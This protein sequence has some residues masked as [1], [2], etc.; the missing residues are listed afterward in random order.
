M[1]RLNRNPYKSWLVNTHK[2]MEQIIWKHL[3]VYNYKALNYN[4][5]HC[6]ALHCTALHYTTHHHT[7]LHYT[8]LNFTALHW[9]ASHC[10]A[11]HCHALH[12]TALHCTTLHCTAMNLYK[13]IGY[14]PGTVPPVSRHWS[15]QSGESNLRAQNLARLV[16]MCMLGSGRDQSTL[17]IWQGRKAVQDVQWSYRLES[18][19]RLFQISFKKLLQGSNLH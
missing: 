13:T 8:S 6:T 2:E 15:C 9:S 4:R 17:C 7:A 19:L 11:L 5:M 10:T 14:I 1:A 16:V 12:C 3:L 18:S